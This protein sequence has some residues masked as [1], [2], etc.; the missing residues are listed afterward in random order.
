MCAFFK[1]LQSQT[2]FFCAKRQSRNF[3]ACFAF[4]FC[5][6]LLFV[7]CCRCCSCCHFCCSLAFHLITSFDALFSYF[8]LFFL[9]F[10]TFFGCYLCSI[11]F[12]WL[13]R[14]RARTFC[15]C[16]VYFLISLQ[17]ELPANSKYDSNS[18][19]SSFSLHFLFATFFGQ[20]TNARHS[21][22]FSTLS[23]SLYCSHLLLQ[24]TKA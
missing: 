4:Y 11:L 5:V 2:N 24:M 9:Y 17:G 19:C 16:C 13:M 10:Y 6:W 21:L 15:C 12:S 7:C 18:T 14:L 1:Y 20:F 22:V 23:R 8:I 3:F